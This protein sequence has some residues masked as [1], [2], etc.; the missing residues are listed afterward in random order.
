MSHSLPIPPETLPGMTTGHVVQRRDHL[1][2]QYDW[3]FGT[4]VPFDVLRHAGDQ[5]MC[6]D[7]HGDR[8]TDGYEERWRALRSRQIKGAMLQTGQTSTHER[9][10]P[11]HA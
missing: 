2:Q 3:R 7:H 6:G 11:W 5:A 1:A 4:Q 8:R 9:I 10:G